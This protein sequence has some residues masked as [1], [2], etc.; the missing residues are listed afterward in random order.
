M[1]QNVETSNAVTTRSVGMRY[2]LISAVIS[3]VYFVVLNVVGIDMTKGFWNW[4]GWVITIV[5]VVLAHKYYKDNGDGYMSYGQGIGIGFWIGLI[6]G[7]IGSIFTYFYIKFI[8]TSFLE[9][10]KER[11]IEGMQR[12][13]MS[14]EQIEQAM[15]FSSM[16]MSAE[17][18][19]IFGFIG[20]IISA[21]I[22][23]LIVTIFT[24]KKNPETTF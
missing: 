16:F 14:D 13:G 18:M 20:G 2:G 7:T 5:I 8:D 17:A 11:Q 3:I 24:Q 19:L 1:E 10:I 4:F 9:M 12:Q 22:I 15:Q 6:S 21:L 23:S